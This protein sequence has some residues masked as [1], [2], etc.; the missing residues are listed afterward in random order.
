MPTVEMEVEIAQPPVIVAEAFLDPANAVFWT[1]DLE[2]FEVVSGKP[3]EVGSV[4]HLHYIQG[5]REY[6]MKDVLEEMIPD[7]Y[8]RSSVSGNGLDAQ[9]ETWLQEVD[10]GTTVRIRWAGSGSSIPMRILLPLM[11]GRL[12]RQTRNEL[13]VFKT[14]VEAH[15][16]HFST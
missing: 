1:T 5:G 16:A 11:R 13:E 12:L 8:F 9:V 6:V 2:R 14:L 3:G 7:Q 15:G 10:S 4:A